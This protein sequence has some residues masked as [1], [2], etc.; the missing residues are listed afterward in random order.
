[1]FLLRSFL[2][3]KINQ[4]KTV[5]FNI[6]CAVFFCQL[7]LLILNIFLSI[8]LKNWGAFHTMTF[9][10]S[11]LPR[12]YLAQYI[13]IQKSAKSTDSIRAI[14]IGGMTKARKTP[15]TKHKTQSPQTFLNIFLKNNTHTPGNIMN[16]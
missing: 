16:N 12:F 7:S 8:P 1:M 14:T 5:Q 10:C 6:N 4:K 15:T 11:L 3:L 9:I 2:N 13:A